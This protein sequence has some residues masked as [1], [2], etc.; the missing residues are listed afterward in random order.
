[1]LMKSVPRIILYGRHSTGLQ[2]VTSSEDQTASCMKLVD[3]LGGTVVGT[4]HDPAESGYKRNR[5]GLK[6]VLHMIEAGEADMVVREALDR[7]A[8]DGEDVAWLGKKL[9]YHAIDLHTVTE[10]HVDQVKFGVAALLGAIFL[11]N[12]VDKTLRGMAAAVAGGRIAGGRSYGYASQKLYDQDGERIRGYLEIA[13]TKAEVVRRIFRD[14]AS[15]LSSIQIARALNEEGVPGPRG[16]EWNASTIRGDPRRHTGILNNPLYVGRLIWGRRQWRRNP[17]S[18]NRERRYRMRERSQ[19]LEIDVPDLRIIDDEL[20]GAVQTEIKR[21]QRTADEIS[22]TGQNRKKHLLSGLIR[23][24]CCGSNYTISGKDYYRCAGQKERGTC[25]NRLSIRKGALE[26]AALSVLQHHLFTEAHARLFVETF[27]REVARI[28]SAQVDGNRALKERLAIVDRELANLS[29]N[30]LSGVLSP[31][32]AKLLSDREAEKAD[33]EVR[34]AQAGSAQPVAQ[35]VPHPI[36]MDMF[37]KKIGA[38]R[39]TLDDRAIRSEA[40]ALMERLI[41]SVIIYPEGANG[42]EAEI[43]SK[44]SDLVEFALNDNAAPKGGVSSSKAVVAGAGF[45]PATFR[46]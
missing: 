39:A 41:E 9:S 10:G 22:P 21:R 8:R 15:G 45:E 26:N 46:L 33:L 4:F 5:P 43:V 30:M 44:V 42:P 3:Y 17:D 27:N 14:F 40:A 25:G 37:A 31:T 38:L 7:L 36:L 34:L 1:M 18:E 32:L 24:S 19:W 23:C 20:W 29:A 11:K 6:Q 12:L 2:K 13:P 35:I 28:S 16:G